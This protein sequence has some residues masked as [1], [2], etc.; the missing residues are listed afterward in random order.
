M[1]LRNRILDNR[2]ATVADHLRHNLRGADAFDLASAYFTI[3][4]YELL[5]DELD[6]VGG[7]RFLFGDPTS[8]EDL[9]PGA[10][11]PKQSYSLDKIGLLVPWATNRSCTWT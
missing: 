7:I 6:K 3:Y 8:V 1:P 2:T 10:R 9:D 11:D 4:G 5:A